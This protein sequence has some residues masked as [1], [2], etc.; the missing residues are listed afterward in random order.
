MVNYIL[1]WIFMLIPFKET[2]TSLLG[3][4]T[5]LL[6][7]HMVLFVCSYLY[8]SCKLLTLL[9]VILGLVLVDECLW[10]FFHSSGMLTIQ[11]C[12]FLTMRLQHRFLTAR[13]CLPHGI[14]FQIWRLDPALTNGLTNNRVTLTLTRWINER[15]K[16]RLVIVIVAQKTIEEMTIAK[17]SQ[18]VRKKDTSIYIQMKFV[19]TGLSSLKRKRICILLSDRFHGFLV[20]SEVYKNKTSDLLFSFCLEWQ[21]NVFVFIMVLLTRNALW[22]AIF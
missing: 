3:N 17:S 22:V 21:K 7:W 14:V 8:N 12:S 18:R 10:A 1:P 15:G 6:N 13:R 5:V 16:N 20:F 2:T 4:V 9:F 19:Y 11:H